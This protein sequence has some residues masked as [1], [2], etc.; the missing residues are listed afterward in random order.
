M[1]GV[2]VKRLVAYGEFEF[3]K[4][5]KALNYPSEIWFDIN[6][7]T[8]HESLSK[9]YIQNLD[10]LILA[11]EFLVTLDD[12]LL[13]NCK[14]IFVQHSRLREKHLN[15][16]LKS[17]LRGQ[18]EELEHICLLASRINWEEEV[19]PFTKEIVLKGLEYTTVP[20]DVKRLFYC[21]VSDTDEKRVETIKGGYDIKRKDGRLVT[22]VLPDDWPWFEMYV[23]PND[24]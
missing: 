9:C 12:L 5:M 21:S 24:Q 15:I 7:F 18:K 2:T 4:T 13:M 23:W 3:E 10:Y 19:V 17:W 14:N 1:K 20:A 16:Y 11:D 8:S 6:P 22:I